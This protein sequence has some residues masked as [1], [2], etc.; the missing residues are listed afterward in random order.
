[1]GEEEED[2]FPEVHEFHLI[3]LGMHYG[4]KKGGREGLF[5]VC[6]CD[7]SGWARMGPV[8]VLLAES[9]PN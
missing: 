8:F 2:G 4:V 7:A 5:L 3:P 1:V 6:S 9:A